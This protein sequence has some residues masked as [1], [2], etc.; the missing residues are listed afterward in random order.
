MKKE[1]SLYPMSLLAKTV[2][3]DL[4]VHLSQ[5]LGGAIGAQPFH[6]ATNAWRTLVEFPDLFQTGGHLVEGWFVIETDDR[7]VMNEHVW[8][9]LADGRIVDPSVLLLVPAHTPVWYFAGVRRTFAETE[10]LEGELFPH[11]RFDGVHGEDGLGHPGYKAAREAARRKVYAQATRVQPPKGLQFLTVQD[12]DGVLPSLPSLPT[13]PAQNEE[14]PPEVS[15]VPLNIPLSC[16]AAREVS[17]RLGGCWYNARNAMCRMPY[18]FMN[19]SYVE[20]WLIGQWADSIRLTEHGWI[21]TAQRGIVDPTI[22]LQTAPTRLE[23]VPGL[24]RSWSHL[25]AYTTC[26]LPI[27]RRSALGDDLLHYQE[28]CQIALAKGEHLAWQTGLPLLP[29]PGGVIKRRGIGPIVLD[30]EEVVWEFPVPSAPSASVSAKL[31]EM[32]KGAEWR[33]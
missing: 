19:A 2:Q 9:E 22:V 23:Y 14:R 32:E 30:V 13:D 1:G 28:A 7:V 12:L 16:A 5:L 3:N 17:A 21:E 6:C 24:R 31:R 27:A 8:C 11:V 4:H 29:E 10:A 25:Q 18:E 26:P 15:G 20:G 33:S